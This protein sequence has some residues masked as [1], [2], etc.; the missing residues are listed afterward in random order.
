MGAAGLITR[1][2]AGPLPGGAGALGG[3][4]EPPCS[5]WG[6]GPVACPAMAGRTGIVGGSAGASV[7]V[8]AG[9]VEIAGADAAGCVR[10]RR[11]RYAPIALT[12]RALVAIAIL[13]RLRGRGTTIVFAGG[14]SSR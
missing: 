2:A 4:L 8:T 7:L 3:L 11:I 5:S 1:R 13:R 9:G 12:A 14:S 10:V 6:S